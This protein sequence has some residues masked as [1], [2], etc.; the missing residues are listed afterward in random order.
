MTEI[1]MSVRSYR[2][3]GIQSY[4]WCLLSC[5]FS[6][7]ANQITGGVYHNVRTLTTTGCE[8]MYELEWLMYELEWSRINIINVYA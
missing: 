6:S 5:F 7:S 3:H 2:A 4:C 8:G 1:I